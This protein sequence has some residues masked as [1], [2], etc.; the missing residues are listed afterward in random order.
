MENYYSE[1]LYHVRVIELFLALISAV[2]CVF[3]C[4]VAL[5]Y[6]GIL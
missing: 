2:L 5:K 1:I 4:M 6:K 3:F